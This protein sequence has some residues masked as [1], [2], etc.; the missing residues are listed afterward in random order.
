MHFKPA[1]LDTFRYTGNDIC[2][3]YNE[4]DLTIYDADLVQF[5]SR[6]TY[7]GVEYSHQVSV[8]SSRA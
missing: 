7:D 2:F 3:G 6:V 4:D 8:V 5:I 1:K